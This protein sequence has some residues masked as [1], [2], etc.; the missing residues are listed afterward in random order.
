RMHEEGYITRQEFDVANSSEIMLAGR[1][2]IGFTGMLH[3]YFTTY[4]IDEVQEKFGYRRLYTEGLRIYTTVNLEYQQAAEEQV[5]KYVAEFANVNVSQGALVSLDA[6]TGAIL[7]MVGGTDFNESEFNRAWQALRQPGS[8]FKPFVY[9]TAMMDG[10]SPNS[11]VRDVQTEFVVEG[12]GTYRPHNYDFG[13]KGIIDLRTALSLSRNIPAVKIVDIVGAHQVA[14]TANSCGITQEIRP[15]LSMGIGTSEVTL[16]EHTSA[17]STFANDGV[18]NVPYAIERITDVR[19][20]VLYSHQQASQRVIES[21]YI[22]MLVSMMQNVVTGGTATR[23]RISGYHIAGKTG[24][25]DDWRD[26]WFMGF[27]PSVVTGVWVGN[28]DNSAMSR[29]TGG[30]YP[31]L[32]WH[33]YMERVLQDYPDELFPAPVLPRVV[34]AMDREDSQALL[35]AERELQVLAEELGVDPEGYTLEQLRAA[36]A[37]GDDVFGNLKSAV[38]Q[39][40]TSWNDDDS[41]GDEEG[42]EDDNS[43]DDEGGDDDSGDDD[44]G[45]DDDDNFVWF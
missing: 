24:T 30:H 25:T 17:Y 7:A 19:G 2:D 21:N 27:T 9:L 38:D 16:L 31:V 22:R 32:I 11:L 1:K 23:A 36:Q 15:A 12:W 34:K 8:S 41:S 6:H 43:G 35:E 39:D 18:R 33:D 3:P 10:Y 28:D 20:N 44:G 37:R 45:E 26:A 29:V 13:Y 4:V 5:E 42:K 14:N 40:P